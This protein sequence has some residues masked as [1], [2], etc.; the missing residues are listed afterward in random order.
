MIGSEGYAG[1][2][3]WSSCDVSMVKTIRAVEAASSLT[4]VVTSLRWFVCACNSPYL[5]F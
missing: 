4:D 5:G 3:K 2:Q 1:D